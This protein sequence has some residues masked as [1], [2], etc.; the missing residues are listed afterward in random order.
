MPRESAS[1]R[2]TAPSPRS[3]MTPS[4]S[5]QGESHFARWKPASTKTPTASSSSCSVVPPTMTRVTAATLASQGLFQPLGKA[6]RDTERD[7]LLHRGVANRLH[8]AEVSKQDALPRGPNALD[9][10]ER[11]GKR[12]ARTHLAVMRDRKSMRLVPDALHQEHSRRVPLL[13]DRLRAARREDLLALLGQREGRDVRVAGRL[14]DLERGAQLSFAAIDKD[15]VGAAREGAITDH[16]GLLAT[17]RRLEPLQAP[18]QHLLQHGEV[19]RAGNELDLEMA[20]V[21]VP[22]A[23]VLEDDH[24]ADRRVSLDVGDVVALDPLRRRLEVERLRERGEHRL[25]AA[26]VVIRLDPQLFE[27]LRRGVGQ[28]RDQRPL[29]PA[30]RHLDGDGPTASLRQPAGEQYR[31]LHCA[32]ENNCARDVRRAGVVLQQKAAQQLALDGV[33]GAVER[34]AV[35]ADHLALAHVGDLDEHLVTA[36]RVSDEVLVVATAGEHLLPIRDP[37]DRLQL[38]PITGRVLEVELA[39][40]RFHPVLQLVDEHVRLPFHEERH[41]VDTRLVILGADAPLTRSW[42]ALDVKVEAHLALLED[43]VRAGAERQQ[44]ADRLDGAAQRLSRRVR[45]VVQGAVLQHPP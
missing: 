27:L 28:L 3:A 14:E 38:I 41:L 21:V 18:A 44:L 11:R 12:L 24:R 4:A 26:A 35:M 8:R 23:P 20:V 6:L 25:R 36:A 17:L 15:E 31:F 5:S 7:D 40:R 37:L 13:H 22:R 39:R 33:T 34:M 1:L 30:L 29:A 42:T 10:V 32:R 16:V 43:L 45:A 9:G 2:T 19:V